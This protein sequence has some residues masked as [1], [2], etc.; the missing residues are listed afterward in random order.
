[1]LQIQALALSHGC[2]AACREPFLIGNLSRG[3]L[4]HC[5]AGVAPQ[6]GLPVTWPVPRVHAVR[7]V[8]MGT[9]ISGDLLSA[10]ISARYILG[11][12]KDNPNVFNTLVQNLSHC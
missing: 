1:M 2:A 11:F 5:S 12:R 7:T 3:L 10:V 6:R 8:A 4:P 9:A